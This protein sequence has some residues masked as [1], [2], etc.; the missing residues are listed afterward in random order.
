[1][2]QLQQAPQAEPRPPQQTPAKP[3]KR[4]TKA[5]QLKPKQALFIKLYTDQKSETFGNALK[6]ALKA[7]YKQEYAEKI[8]GVMSENVAT[9]MTDAMERAGITDEKLVGVLGEG[10]EAKRVISA[11]VTD[12]DADVDTDDFIEVPDH[13][14]RHKFL[15]TAIKL[16]GAYAPEKHELS[17]SSVTFIRAEEAKP[18]KE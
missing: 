5:P 6:S 15:D 18:A 2:D 7:G 11:R 14:T 16:K 3:K 10:L 1:M 12:R 17:G 9:S 13:P 4:K 8:L